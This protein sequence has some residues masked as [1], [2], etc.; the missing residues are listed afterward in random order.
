MLLSLRAR[1]HRTVGLSTADVQAMGLPRI[2]VWKTL[3]FHRIIISSRGKCIV[4]LQSVD[5][6]QIDLVSSQGRNCFEHETCASR[7]A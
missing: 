3:K 5:E 4:L 1:H 7:W 2:G 6:F